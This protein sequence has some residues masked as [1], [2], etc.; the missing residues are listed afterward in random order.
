MTPLSVWI[1][2]GGFLVFCLAAGVSWNPH[3]SRWKSLLPIHGFTFPPRWMFHVSVE[4]KSNVRIPS[5]QSP[6]HHSKISHLSVKK[7]FGKNSFLT[8][9]V[10]HSKILT[11]LQEP[12]A[13]VTDRFEGASIIVASSTHWSCQHKSF[14][15]YYHSYTDS[16]ILQLTEEYFSFLKKALVSFCWYFLYETSYSVH[17]FYCIHL[18]S[19]VLRSPLRRWTWLEDGLLN[20]VRQ[21]S[22]QPLL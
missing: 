4:R 1:S 14:S 8:Y 12:H 2:S 10:H 18:H 7:K 20:F 21:L 3:A 9:L 22:T 19:A 17:C 5:L 6:F 16:S 11:S 15:S 13:V